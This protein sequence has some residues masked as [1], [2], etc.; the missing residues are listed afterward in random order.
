MPVEEIITETDS[1]TSD[2]IICH[3][4]KIITKY[5]L[6][7]K[8]KIFSP[9]GP[10]L[11]CG[12][13]IEPLLP[14]IQEKLR[15]HY[16]DYTES[17]VHKTD[18]TALKHNQTPKSKIDKQHLNIEETIKVVSKRINEK[19]NKLHVKKE[20][21]PLSEMKSINILKGIVNDIS[22]ILK[23]YN[24]GYT[25]KWLIHDI[26]ANNNISRKK[27]SIYRLTT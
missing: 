7:K 2:E 14:T 1:I 16:S 24:F 27:I 22:E 25:N 4:Y 17:H 6:F 18:K 12:N 21:V 13:S 26:Q 10:N 19:I 5:S 9:N 11:K 8:S 3:K 15:N 23:E 20:E